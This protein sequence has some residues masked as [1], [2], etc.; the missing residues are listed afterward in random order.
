MAKVT[1]IT[2][3]HIASGTN[4]GAYTYNN[5]VYDLGYILTLCSPDR[6]LNPEFLCREKN[7]SNKDYVEKLGIEK[8]KIDIKYAKFKAIE[9]EIIGTVDEHTK[10]LEKL[11]IPGSSIKGYIMNVLWYDI[12]HS[13]E[14]IR[15]EIISMYDKKFLKDRNNVKS[16]VNRAVNAQ[17]AYMQELLETTDLIFDAQL[18]ICLNKRYK[19]YSGVLSVKNYVEVLPKGVVWEG[20][21]FRL[22]DEYANKIAN[23]VV[24]Q[25]KEKVEKNTMD[26]FD[27]KK[28]ECQNQIIREIKDRLNKDRFEEW[29]KTT[30]KKFMLKVLEYE[31]KFVDECSNQSVNLKKLKSIYEDILQRLENNEIIIQIGKFTNF[32][33]K[34]YDIAFGSYFDDE[35]NFKKI[36][37]PKDNKTVPRLDTMNLIEENKLGSIPFGFLKIEL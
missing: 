15:N 2:P 7:L 21:L 33:L 4:Y 13:N 1:V 37:S 3:I 16:S 28:Q 17:I 26:Q 5:Y 23:K 30:N 35:E 29:F 25:I 20:N 34:S 27:A 24:T 32:I 14:K 10:S 9:T 36:F 12:I 6:C 18:E 31:K 8:S 11:T 19:K 22:K